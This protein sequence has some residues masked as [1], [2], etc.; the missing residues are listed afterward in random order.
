MSTV[1]F[2][3]QCPQCNFDEAMGSLCI[4]TGAESTFCP[5]CGYSE[6]I[7]AVVDRQRQ[8]ADPE[9]R[10]WLKKRK[11]GHLAYRRIVHQGYGAYCLWADGVGCSGSFTRPLTRQAALQWFRSE[12]KRTGTDLKRCFV[13]WWNEKTQR[14]EI[15]HG[16]RRRQYLI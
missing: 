9:K 16:S 13:S 14:V 15:L 11:D 2:P 12:I 7:R 5:M 3:T 6:K 1:T 10:C 8:A 4:R